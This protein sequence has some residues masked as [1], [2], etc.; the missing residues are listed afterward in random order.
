MTESRATARVE[1]GDVKRTGAAGLIGSA[2]PAFASSVDQT[3]AARQNN[4]VRKKIDQ[5]TL[6]L[7][8]WS[9][10]RLR[11][12]STTNIRLNLSGSRGLVEQAEEIEQGQKQTSR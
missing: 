1:F 4:P 2:R 10:V 8:A 9:V 7:P 5:W 11:F 12:L 3:R 6:F